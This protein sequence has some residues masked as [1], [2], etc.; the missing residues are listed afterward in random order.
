MDGIA[1]VPA[2]SDD[3]GD[4]WVIRVNPGT[5]WEIRGRTVKYELGEV[6]MYRLV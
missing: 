5:V 3:V 1:H 6:Q 2:Y 4:V